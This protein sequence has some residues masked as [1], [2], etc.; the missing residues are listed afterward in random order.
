MLDSIISDAFKGLILNSTVPASSLLN[1][2]KVNINHCI[3]SIWF[4][5]TL[6]NS[7]RFSTS[8]SSFINSVIITIEVNGVFN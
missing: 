6:I 1:F 8:F 4:C 2:S 3:L 5:T 7:A